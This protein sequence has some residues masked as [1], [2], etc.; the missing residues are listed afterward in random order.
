VAHCKTDV[1][2]KHEADWLSQRGMAEVL[3]AAPEIVLMHLRYVFVTQELDAEATA[4]D[5]LVVRTEGVRQARRRIRH[6]NLNA[7]ISVGCRT[8][9]RRAS[10]SPTTPRQS[11]RS[12]ATPAFGSL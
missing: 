8:D 6:C 2:L 12:S 11:W 10:R 7:I 3:A 5:F 9:S 4:K 1:P